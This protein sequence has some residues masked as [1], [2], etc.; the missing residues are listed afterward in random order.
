MYLTQK[1]L[2][3]S[4]KLVVFFVMTNTHGLGSKKRFCCKARTVFRR[5]WV[6]EPRQ[7]QKKKKLRKKCC[8]YRTAR[9]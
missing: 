2:L 6:K 1:M 9:R 8:F 4:S 7:I 3:I 5:G